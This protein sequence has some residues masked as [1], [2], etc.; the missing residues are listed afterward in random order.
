[1]ARLVKREAPTEEAPQTDAVVGRELQEQQRRENEEAADSFE[2]AEGLGV[3]FYDDGW[4]YGR[5]DK[6]P[7]SDE[8]RYGEVRIKH[9][10]T[11]NVWVPARDVRRVV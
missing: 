6:V 9:A 11:G 5:V 1:M 10:Q 3:Q 2:G 7:I 4:R 8:K